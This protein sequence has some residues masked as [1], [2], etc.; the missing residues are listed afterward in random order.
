MSTYTHLTQEERYHIETMRKQKVSL[1]QIAAGMGR[2]PSTLGR[3]LKRNTGLRGYRYKQAHKTAQQRHADKPKA[4]KML[5]ELK[6][7][8]T[9]HLEQQWSPEQISGRLK[10]ENKPSV[11]HETIYRLVSEDQKAGGQ[12]FTH[13]RHQAKPYRKRYGKHDYRGRIPNRVDIDQRPA[14]VEEKI[15]LGDWEADTVIGKG[16]KA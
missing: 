3:E 13:L 16:H 15:R 10:Q 12:L 8:V 2:H 14:I 11:S 6:A 7:Y 1:N 9:E 5:G 4:V